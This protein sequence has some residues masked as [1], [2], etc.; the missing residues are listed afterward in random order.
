MEKC[1]HFMPDGDISKG[2][3]GY[4]R[5]MILCVEYESDLSTPPMVEPCLRLDEIDAVLTFVKE[6]CP[7]GWEIIGGKV[8]QLK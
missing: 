1:L 8:R 3:F 6:R 4:S 5:G 2:E 7:G